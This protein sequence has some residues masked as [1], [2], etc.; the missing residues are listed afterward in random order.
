MPSDGQ[1][2]NPGYTFE[3]VSW[4]VGE[5]I[6]TNNRDLMELLYKMADKAGIPTRRGEVAM[7]AIEQYLEQLKEEDSFS[8]HF[9]TIL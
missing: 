1:A 3:T 2:A 6:A 4:L 7:E 8:M 5:G 9:D